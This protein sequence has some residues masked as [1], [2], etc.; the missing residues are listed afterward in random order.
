MGSVA[1]AAVATGVGLVAASQGKRNDTLDFA[2]TVAKSGGTCLGT[3]PDTRCSQIDSM[4]R[5]VDTLRNAAIGVYI[6]AGA[7]V[8]GTVS[9]LILSS[10]K[11]KKAA[12]LPR[13]IQIAPVASGEQGGMVVSGVF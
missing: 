2:T 11:P 6:G 3:M 5:K 13:G 7:L 12:S 4:A 9:Y 1:L 8:V 10:P